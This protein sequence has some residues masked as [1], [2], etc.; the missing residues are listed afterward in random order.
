VGSLLLRVVLGDFEDR[1][2]VNSLNNGSCGPQERV[3]PKATIEVGRPSESFTVAFSFVREKNKRRIGYPIQL[4]TSEHIGPRIAG[5]RKRF[6]ELAIVLFVGPGGFGTRDIFSGARRRSKI[7]DSRNSGG[8]TRIL[9][10]QDIVDKRGI[11]I[12]KHGFIFDERVLD[13]SRTLENTA[14]LRVPVKDSFDVLHSP[15]RVLR[16]CK[17]RQGQRKDGKLPS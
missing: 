12:S 8:A 11:G 7:F 10:L 16:K 15:Q 6:T 3:P 2:T 17:K 9:F 13:G 1:E 4:R 5:G 14:A